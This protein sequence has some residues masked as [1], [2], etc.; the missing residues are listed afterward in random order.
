MDVSDLNL[1]TY[2]MSPKPVLEASLDIYYQRELNKL[3]TVLDSQA[4]AIE[5]L[6]N[7]INTLHP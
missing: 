2:S 7:E 1:R 4:A 3:K 5:L 6:L